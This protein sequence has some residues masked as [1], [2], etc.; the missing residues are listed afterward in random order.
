MT[1]EQA[2]RE[3]KDAGGAMYAA[4]CLLSKAFRGWAVAFRAERTRR[5][6][7]LRKVAERAGISATFLSDCE[8]GRRTPNP[9]MR[10]ILRRSLFSGTGGEKE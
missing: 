4:Q 5:S 7:S 2:E 3:I 8:L 9:E 6:L 1:V 10:S